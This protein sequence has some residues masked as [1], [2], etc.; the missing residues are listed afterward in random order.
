M[1]KFFVATLFLCVALIADDR[2]ALNQTLESILGTKTY[3]A[4]K[5]FLGTVFKQKTLYTD[6]THVDLIRVLQ[7]LKENKIINLSLKG[8]Q[9]VSV[10]FGTRSSSSFFVKV[11]SDALRNIGYYK[12]I[13][14]NSRM[15]DS[16]FIWTIQYNGGLIIDPIALETELSKTGSHLVDAQ[17]ESPSSWNYEID[18]TNAHLNVD[19]LS[20]G[21]NLNLE[22]VDA[23]KWVEISDVSKLEIISDSAN[24]WYPY[25]SFYDKNLNLLKV[26]KV[27]KKTSFLNLNLPSESVYMKISDL[28]ML[29]NMKNGLNIDAKE[30]R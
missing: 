28:Y 4:N 3:N 9:A 12:Y 11:L 22:Q 14:K 20:A 18:T 5:T 8:S 6:G 7:T 2:A 30:P 10:S 23:E 27:D 26:E 25:V 15:D 16:K 17:M 13:T 29:S 24:N 19:K 21:D 1:V